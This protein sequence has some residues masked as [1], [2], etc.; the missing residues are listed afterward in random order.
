MAGVV[1]LKRELEMTR[2]FSASCLIKKKK[3][4][5]N[6]HKA[7]G[8]IE[9]IYGFFI[10]AVTNALSMKFLISPGGSRMLTALFGLVD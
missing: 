8:L 9:R 6:T 10:L 7:V 1:S 2:Y 5:G 3:I 4:T